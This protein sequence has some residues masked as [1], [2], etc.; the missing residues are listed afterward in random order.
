VKE[1][2]SVAGHT[3]LAKE[4][5]KCQQNSAKKKERCFNATIE[6]L[7]VR[8]RPLLP[9][10]TALVSRGCVARPSMALPV[11]RLTGPFP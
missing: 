7:N 9:S 6:P 3:E 4:F 5:G 8:C 10:M 11:P 1:A 2:L